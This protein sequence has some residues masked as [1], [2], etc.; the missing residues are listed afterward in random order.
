MRCDSNTG[1]GSLRKIITG[2]VLEFTYGI[3]STGLLESSGIPDFLDVWNLKT[4][5]SE[6]LFR[7]FKYWG[8]Y[9]GDKYENTGSFIKSNK[10]TENSFYIGVNHNGFGLS[11]FNVSKLRISDGILS[12]EY[13]LSGQGEYYS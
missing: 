9:S 5:T 12:G 1:T 13:L 11:G 10:L 2:D 8:H 7:D 3:I 6:F 4:G